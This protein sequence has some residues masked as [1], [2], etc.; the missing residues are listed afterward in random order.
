M[1][2]LRNCAATI[3][4]AFLLAACQAAPPPPPPPPPAPVSI[5]TVGLASWYKPKRTMTRTAT[6]E[7]FDGDGLTAASRTLPLNS[8]ARVTN[9]ENGRSVIVRINDRGP[10]AKERIIDVSQRAARE[11]GMTDHGVTR[12]RVEPLTAEGA[13]AAP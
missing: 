7:H 4:V 9:L 11:L 3:A 10:F 1:I 5:G 2:N 13:S 12:V 6:G 8:T